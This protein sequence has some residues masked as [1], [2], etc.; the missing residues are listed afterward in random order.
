MLN[1]IVKVK[2]PFGIL[3][4]SYGALVLKILIFILVIK[5]I[6]NILNREKV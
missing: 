5:F 4:L 2:P 6:S 3:V 1:N